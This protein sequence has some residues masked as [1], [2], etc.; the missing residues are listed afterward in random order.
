MAE[1]QS[2]IEIMLSKGEIL[3]KMQLLD[4]KVRIL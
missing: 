4:T 2:K 3:W 1:R